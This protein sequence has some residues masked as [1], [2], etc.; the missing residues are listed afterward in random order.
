MKMSRFIVMMVAVVVTTAH[1]L[2]QEINGQMEEK[3]DSVTLSIN[4]TIALKD[5][6]VVTM[7]QLVKTL[8]DR[9]SYNVQ[10]DPEASTS[11]VLD[12]LRKVPLVSVDGED[13]VRVNGGGN[14]K[15]Y[16]NG[17]PDPSLSTNPREV[18]R[19]MP[20]SVIKRIEVITEPGARY[21]AEGATAIL[22]IVTVEGVR[23]EGM[24]GTV[25]ASVN[26]FWSP[27]ASAYIA[28]RAGKFTLS[29]TGFYQKQS[30]RQFAGED[31]TWTT[32]KD[33]GTTMYNRYRNEQPAWVYSLNLNASL[34]I[35]S[36]NLITASF[37]GYRYGLNIYGDS[38]IEYHDAAGRLITSY[39]NP[40]N[41][42]L[43]GCMSW[44]G[45]ADWEHRTSHKD[46]VLTASYMFST[47]GQQEEQYDSLINLVNPP[48]DYTSYNKWGKERF[49]EHT[50]QLDYQLPLWE[51]HL[52]EVGGKYIL[53]LNKSHN[54]M[55]YDGVA[56]LDTD[57]R[58]RHNMH[59]GAAYA[60]WR[61]RVG[62]V[63]LRGGLRYEYSHFRAS[64]PNGD[65]DPFGRDLH[66]LVPSASVH[67]QLSPF[68]S[69]R[70]SW[71]TSLNRPGIQYLNPAVKRYTST[72][73]YGN[74]HLSSARNSMLSINFQH[75]GSRLTFNVKPSLTITNNL[76]G[77]L[78]TAHDG[79]VYLTNSNDCRYLMAGVGGFVQ[80]MMTSKTTL[81]MNGE[82][83]YKRYRNPS[84]GLTNNG[85][86]GNLY[87]QLSQQLPW[88]LRATATCMW[89]GIG[90]DLNHVY[91]YSTMP[92]PTIMLRLSRS[93]LKENRLTVRLSA[94]SILHK[95]QVDKLYVTQGD[96]VSH[97]MGRYNQRNV[98][99]SVSYAFGS[100][101]TR[102]KQTETTV[103]ND[104]LVGGL[105]SGN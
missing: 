92:D 18:L 81:Y 71:A 93:F 41:V 8:D 38:H 100:S 58:F 68:N 97:G 69:L 49:I 11:T 78:R 40:F 87:A 59:V 34:E 22:N 39:D 9:L 17:H 25:S 19:A 83:C 56:E 48:F 65:G 2:A 5:V 47:T 23:I 6:E 29:A 37:G 88:Q 46:E 43:Y 84:Q 99:V 66:D 53:R 86:G 85:W 82:L 57:T 13:N 98:Q 33:T 103:E 31:E 67:W 3:Q 1:G 64:F 63:T 21:D 91:G 94:N 74:P 77:T 72:I 10:A 105:R 14:F 4:D 54:R 104:D 73:E 52:L 101:N 96:Y 102:V 42:P 75:T 70:L 27:N 60:S 12:M 95:H 62:D 79:I 28:A 76:I 45:R 15:I 80:W 90:H 32:Y 35:D 89:Y 61:Y 44:N 24:N 20:A 16:K 50:W 55:N 36:L 26:S 7:R 51:H 30:H